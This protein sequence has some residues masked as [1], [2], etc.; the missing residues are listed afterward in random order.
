MCALSHP[1]Q[2]VCRDWIFRAVGDVR[3]FIV[4]GHNINNLRY[5][6]DTVL[7]AE[8]ES[9]LQV[10][11]SSVNE[12]GRKYGMKVNI[13]KTKVMVISRTDPFPEINILLNGS[14]LQ[15]V[16]TM[17]YLGHLISSNGKCEKEIKRR[18]EIARG[19]FES[20]RN[21]LTSRNIKIHTRR[22]LTQGY[23]WSTLLYGAE[24]WTLSKAT[25]KK[26]ASFEMWTY[27]RILKITWRD[28]VSNQ[29]VL[30]RMRTKR[31]LI[32]S[33]KKRKLD[34]FGHLIRNDG[35]QRELLEGKIDGRRGRGRPRLS[36]MGNI[37]EWT[38]TRYGQCV[39]RAQER[40]R[41][42]SMVA[43]LLRAEDTDR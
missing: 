12:E 11:L 5:A 20:M 10:L 26:I 39:R 23:I 19:A 16:S 9:D 33:V 14:K 7:L 31:S 13:D 43:N 6:D 2:F 36:W 41:W 37:K 34:Y 17:V 15:Q 24:T 40:S 38:S 4:G 35:L 28:R 29:E 25:I 8:N 32:T 1:F 3:G 18:I 30:R 42:R 27:R 21:V 22:K